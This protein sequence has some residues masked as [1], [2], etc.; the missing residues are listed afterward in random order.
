MTRISNFIRNAKYLC[1]GLSCRL[2]TPS[3]CPSC[4]SVLAT[5]VDRKFFHLLKEC[6]TCRLLYRYPSES[7]SGMEV[8]Y[9]EN[10]A[11]PGLTTELP[12]DE[13]LARLLTTKFKDSSKDFTY[14]MGVLRALGLRDGARLLDYGANWG[15]MSWQF[16]QA[17]FDVTAFEI[18]APRAAYGKKLGVEIHTSLGQVGQG[19][20]MVYSCHVLEHVPDP[21]ETLRH[22][23]TLVRPG[24]LVVAHTPNGSSRHRLRHRELFHQTWG[25]VH[26]VL[27]TDRFVAHAA[28]DHPFLIT[29]DDTPESVRTWDQQSQELRDTS[30]AGFFFAIR[31]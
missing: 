23:L 1:A 19:F 5:T 14:H 24:G 12:D 11:Q 26:P 18:S 16:L 28:G 13:N 15:Y 3:S 17:G 31:R 22:Q 21:A 2:A 25:K 7:A 9:Q 20:D 8:F 30:G 4:H 29:S 10:Y 27:L 6:G